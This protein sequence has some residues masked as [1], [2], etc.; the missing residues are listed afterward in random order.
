MLKRNCM[1]RRLQRSLSKQHIFF[2]ETCQIKLVDDSKIMTLVWC[3]LFQDSLFL[4]CHL[5]PFQPDQ[6]AS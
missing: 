4:L 6:Q 5:P 2:K 1:H 3:Y